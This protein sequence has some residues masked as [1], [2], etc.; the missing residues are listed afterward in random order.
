MLKLRKGLKWPKSLRWGCWNSQ[1]KSG[2]GVLR[3]WLDHG[4]VLPPTQGFPVGC[5]FAALIFYLCLENL[6]ARFWSGLF[7]KCRPHLCFP[8]LEH[9]LVLP[10]T[11]DWACCEQPFAAACRGTLRSLRFPLSGFL[12]RRR[13]TFPMF[14]EVLRGTIPPRVLPFLAAVLFQRKERKE[15]GFYHRRVRQ[16]SSA[17]VSSSDFCYCACEKPVLHLCRT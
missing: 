8:Q 14:H 11:S 4:A 13:D 6:A 7:G 17:D 9:S 10:K 15:T 1:T 3:L 16:H 2:L 12:W 5:C